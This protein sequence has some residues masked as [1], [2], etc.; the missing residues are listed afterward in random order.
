MRSLIVC[1][2][3][4]I[5]PAISSAQSNEDLV[6][7]V[8]A[9]LHWAGSADDR[10]ALVVW[11]E[12]TFTVDELRQVLAFARTEAGRKL[13]A[14]PHQV[15]LKAR[16]AQR[17]TPVGYERVG[18]DVKAP[19]LVHR[20][21]P[22]YPAEAR[23]AFISGIVIIEVLIDATGNVAD[24]TVLK[25]LPHGLD[26]AAVDAV[27]QW[28]FEPATKNGAAVPVVFNLTVNFKLH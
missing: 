7:E 11:L 8:A 27:R 17:P 22:V 2:L 20:V 6:R 23:A 28:K 9:T 3:L 13:L 5:L 24:A 19:N 1:A 14:F 26:Q 10:A 12:K 4:L 16:L 15:S 25:G 21:E 18:A